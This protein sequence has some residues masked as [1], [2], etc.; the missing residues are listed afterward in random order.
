MPHPLLYTFT[1]LVRKAY[2][3]A[4][5]KRVVIAGSCNM[6]GWC[7]TRLNLSYHNT[8]IS[9]EKQFEKLKRDFADYRRFEIMERTISGLLLFRCT[10]LDENNLCSDHENRPEYCREYP[11]PELLFLGG[12]L[13]EEC[14]YRFETVPDFQRVLKK[15]TRKTGRGAKPPTV[16]GR[17]PSAL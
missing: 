8:W 14:G 10:M 9:S 6:C 13:R 4:T 11:H 3:G 7:C 2:L 15:E 5:R 16:L 17:G 1:G 12:S